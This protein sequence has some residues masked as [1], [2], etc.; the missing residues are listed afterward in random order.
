MLRSFKFGDELLS[1]SG[2]CRC[3]RDHIQSLHRPLFSCGVPRMPRTAVV[4]CLLS[5][6]AARQYEHQWNVYSMAASLLAEEDQ[7][8][9]GMMPTTK[10][11]A[12]HYMVVHASVHVQ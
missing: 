9:E 5:C 4:A 1:F 11:S 2:G 8:D 10:L 12:A 7:P 6:G 3:C